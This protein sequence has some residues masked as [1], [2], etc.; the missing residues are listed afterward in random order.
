MKTHLNVKGLV[1]VALG[2]VLLGATG[3]A[4]DRYD[5]TAG[6]YVDDSVTSDRIEDSL[7]AN[8]VYKFPHVGVTTYKGT[9]QL[10]GFVNTE[11]QKT[12]AEDI[13]K[14]VPGVKD[15]INNISV[16]E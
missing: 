8:A 9:V 3:C 13:A 16:K 6:Q 11:E 7:E 10:H 1:A 2:G 4:T 5:R 14:T 12:Q 15:V